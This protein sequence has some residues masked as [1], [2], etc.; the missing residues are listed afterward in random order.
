M[1]LK[2]DLADHLRIHNVH[3]LVTYAR[4][5][6]IT[7][8]IYIAYRPI[9]RGRAYLPAAWQVIRPEFRTDND[10]NAY[11]RDLGHKTFTVTSEKDRDAARDE[12]VRWAEE[13]YHVPEW[14][15]TPPGLRPAGL[16]PRVVLDAVKAALAPYRA[17][18]KTSAP[19]TRG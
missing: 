7:P 9:Q 4:D 5:H 3:N 6:G 13:R 1:T 12:A 15:K 8:A 19:V 16:L 14:V 18:A 2:A 10:P 11:W 17:A